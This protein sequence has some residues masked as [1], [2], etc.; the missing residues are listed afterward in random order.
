MATVST[1]NPERR[2]PRWLIIAAVVV[3]VVIALLLLLLANI[4]SAVEA[5]NNFLGNVL[6]NANRINPNTAIDCRTNSGCSIVHSIIYSLLFIFAILTGFAYTTLLERKFIAWFQQ[7]SGPNR[8]GPAGLLQPLADAIKLI[9]KEDIM[10]SGADP[11][12]YRVAP[13]LKSVPALV[14][15]AVVPLGPDLLIPWFDGNV[16]R[17]PMGLVDINV[18]VLWLLAVTS[19]GTYGV[20]LAGWAS[21]NKYAMLGGLRASAQM[22]SYEL[23]L[24]LTMAVPILIVGSMSLGDIIRS[25]QYF[26][27]WFVFQNPLAAGILFIALMA[28]INRSPFDLPEAEQELTQGFMTEYSGMKFAQF[29]MA[30][31]LGMIGVSVVVVTLFFGGYQDGFGIVDYLPVLAP[32][33]IIGKVILFLIGMVWIRATLPR[34]R[35]DRLMALGWKILLPLALIAVAWSAIAVLIAD[36]LGG[37]TAY[38]IAAGVVFLLILL[39]GFGLLRGTRADV[40]PERLENDPIVTGERRGLGWMLLQILGGIIAIP[41]GLFTG[42]IALLERLANAIPETTKAEPA[43]SDETA[44]TVSET[45]GE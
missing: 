20:V 41:F 2:I 10:P 32:L 3:L 29:M 17:V 4:D 30:E 38:A 28:E 31:Y 25:Q 1:T 26:F 35:Y 34:I 27:Q 37:S 6:F 12:V 7:R 43:K 45:S 19:V 16:Y 36:S 13:I 42:T 40:E 22:L 9:F 11:W 8:V 24:G 14:L 39:L 15:L 18:G 44:I 5:L 23:S 21:N 33:V